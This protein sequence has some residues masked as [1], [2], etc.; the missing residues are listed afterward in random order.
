MYVCMYVCMYMCMYVCMYVCVYISVYILLDGNSLLRCFR[1]NEMFYLM[2]HSKHFI[3]GVIWTYGNG[4]LSKKENPLL[5][6][7]GQLFQISSKSSFIAQPLLLSLA[8]HW[9]EWE[10]APSIMTD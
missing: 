4:P 5:P 7:R 8:E 6:L 9:L 10:T 1:R 3:Y 2:T